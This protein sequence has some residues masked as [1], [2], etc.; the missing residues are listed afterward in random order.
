MKHATI[1]CLLAVA[2]WWLCLILL[3]KLLFIFTVWSHGL[4]KSSSM[5][6]LRCCSAKY[7]ICHT[8][9][10][11]TLCLICDH[12]R[13]ERIRIT[14]HLKKIF[15]DKLF[16]KFNFKTKNKKSWDIFFFLKYNFTLILTKNRP[17]ARSNWVFLFWTMR[18]LKW[19]FISMTNTTLIDQMVPLS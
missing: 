13:A 7:H 10:W 19:F 8:Y 9:K 11:S 4:P 6:T 12:A 3:K 16:K 15:P 2:F 1:V 17:P 14:W 18:T 5:C